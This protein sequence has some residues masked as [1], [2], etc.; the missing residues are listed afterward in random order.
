MSAGVRPTQQRRLATV[1]GKSQNISGI[2]AAEIT[3]KKQVFCVD[4]LNPDVSAEKMDEIQQVRLV[5]ETNG[6][7]SVMA[8][9]LQMRLMR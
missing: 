9:M 5:A 2:S 4:N 3:R 8:N 6:Y 1:H 7:V